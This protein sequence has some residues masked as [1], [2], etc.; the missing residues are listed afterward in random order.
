M[1]T[2][3][4]LV[5]PDEGALD[6]LPHAV[7]AIAILPTRTNAAH[8]QCVH[9]ATTI[10]V[11]RRRDHRVFGNS[12]N[13]LR[14]TRATRI[15]VAH[16]RYASAAV[17]LRSNLCVRQ[18]KW[19]V[20]VDRG[21]VGGELFDH[22][23]E[24]DR[25]AR[26]QRKR[27]WYLCHRGGTFRCRASDGTGNSIDEHANSPLRLRPCPNLQWRADGRHSSLREV[28]RQFRNRHGDPVANLSASSA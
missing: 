17:C 22:R 15:N 6:E 2:T 23:R 5:V 26:Q 27:E 7:I 18:S 14:K 4:A 10:L 3:A 8:Q 9:R 16:W 25:D 11:Q 19:A 28:Q 20:V 24:P 13:I 12:L 21:Y 1:P